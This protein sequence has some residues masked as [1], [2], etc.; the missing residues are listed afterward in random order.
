MTAVEDDG[1]DGSGRA[2]YSAIPLAPDNAFEA[3]SNRRRRRVILS[4]AHSDD[5]L[6]ARELS[7]ELAAIEHTIDPSAVTSEQ[8]TRI[9]IS[10]IQ[11]HLQTLD[12]LGVIDYDGRSKSA[13]A[14]DA[15]A[16]LAEVVQQVT[17]ACYQPGGDDA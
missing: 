9:Y 16:S 3:I 13:S 7:V 5:D 12:D 17:T 14:T 4:L 2:T 1:N 11:N 15:T 6:T 8:R 10:L